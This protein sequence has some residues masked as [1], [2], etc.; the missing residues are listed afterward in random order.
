MPTIINGTTGID[1][2][3]DG[4]ITV[5]KIASGAVTDA[6]IAAMAAT[7]LTGQVP[8]ANAPSGSVIQVVSATYAT[9]VSTSGGTYI[10]SGLTASITPSSSANKVLV[11]ITDP[12]R[13]VGTV[14]GI[15]LALYRNGSSI[16]QPM[17]SFGYS[18]PSTADFSSLLSFSY[19]DSP[20]TT[21]STSY[22]LYFH[23]NNSGTAY[24]QIDNNIGNTANIILMEIA[25]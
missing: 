25:A 8:D 23:V 15:N 5:N 14:Q 12:M 13:K 19:L 3:Q 24:A 2:I 10:S 18:N 17:S 4:I 9:Q 6:K 16:Y 21:A 7:K 20:A 11:I 1:T 22:T